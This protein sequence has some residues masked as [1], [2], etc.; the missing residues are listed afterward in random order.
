MVGYLKSFQLEEV[1]NKR[2]IEADVERWCVAVA[3]ARGV[4]DMIGGDRRY[5]SFNARR[6]CKGHAS[7]AVE[8]LSSRGTLRQSRGWTGCV[9]SG[10][11]VCGSFGC[12]TTMRFMVLGGVSSSLHPLERIAA[13]WRIKVLTDSEAHSSVC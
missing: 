11:A 12:A 13:Q 4:V 8:V 10:P 9:V 3:A 6:Q 5:A 7:A 1:D 2:W